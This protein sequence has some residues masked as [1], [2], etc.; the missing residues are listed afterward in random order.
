[1]HSQASTTQEHW[2]K[3]FWG[4]NYPR[5]SKIKSEIDPNMTFWTSPGINADHMEAVDG[6]ACLIANPSDE[7]SLIP[8]PTDRQVPADLA[9]D[10]HF[11]FGNRELFGTRYPAPGTW[12]GLQSPE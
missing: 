12:E 9:K 3:A 5:L 1:M 6:R 4:T 7:P 8:P 11:L 2:T 10:G